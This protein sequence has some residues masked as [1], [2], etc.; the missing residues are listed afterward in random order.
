M[1]ER[2]LRG[3]NKFDAMTLAVFLREGAFTGKES[4]RKS[5][6]L[7]FDPTE[8]NQPIKSTVMRRRVK[9]IIFVD[10]NILKVSFYLIVP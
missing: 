8:I 4:L 2:K 1:L 6:L 10:T 5:I 3:D 7:E 9:V